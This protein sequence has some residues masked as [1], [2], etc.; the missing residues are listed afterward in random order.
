M[1]RPRRLRALNQLRMPA[2]FRVSVERLGARRF[3]AGLSQPTLAVGR[4]NRSRSAAGSTSATGQAGPP[5]AHPG[6]E[7][8]GAEVEPGIRP[9]LLVRDP[10]AAAARCTSLGCMPRYSA[11]SRVVS[12]RGAAGG[13]SAPRRAARRSARRSPSSVSCSGLRW[14]VSPDTCSV[15]RL[16]RASGPRPVC[17]HNDR[18][19][20]PAA[21]WHPPCFR[22]W[23]CEVAG[24]AQGI[25]VRC[26]NPALVND[27][28]PPR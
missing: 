2:Q 11:A 3:R 24:Q 15:R 8:V 4:S 23:Q 21:C 9:V 13:A 26:A 7:F 10:P 22:K 27:R 14:T 1:A 17:A 18:P 25:L 12:H 28:A 5:V 19:K 20:L 6:V 16:P